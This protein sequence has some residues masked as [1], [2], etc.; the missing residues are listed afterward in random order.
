MKKILLATVFVFTLFSFSTTGLSAQQNTPPSMGQN[1]VEAVVIN[2]IE[3]SEIIENTGNKHPY[4]KLELLGLSGKYKGKKMIIE[5]GKYDQSGVITYSAGDTIVVAVEK[6]D[7]AQDMLTITDYVRR[8]PLLFLFSIF[9]ILAISIGGRRGASSLI[10][11]GVTFGILF[12]FVLPQVSKGVSPI[13]VVVA[14]SSLIIPITFSLSHGINKKTACAIIGTLI[15]LFITGLLSAYFVNAAH[16]SG[17]ASEE[18]SYLNIIKKGSID[19]KGLLLGGIIIGLLGVLQD[20]TVSQ[21][22][23]VY[24]LKSANRSIK[25]YELFKRAMDVGRDHIASMVNTLILV[26]AGA[27]LPLLLLFIN[28]P[29]PFSSVINFE[30]IAEEVVRTLVSSIGL[31]LAVPITTALTALFVEVTYKSKGKSE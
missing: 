7:K 11:M 13:L 15:A 3:N 27:S 28:N 9:A 31:I 22:A 6:N 19:I 17:F 8:T 1:S 16:L 18:A 20:I 4:Q 10:G 12:L 21:A 25:L 30:I 26:Y 5:N 2:V 14:A 29:L 24:Q 23:I